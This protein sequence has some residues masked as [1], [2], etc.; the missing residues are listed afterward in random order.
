M[1]RWSSKK[2]EQKGA[3]GQEETEHEYLTHTIGSVKLIIKMITEG[4][5]R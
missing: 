3:K 1:G 5:S 4:A 2:A